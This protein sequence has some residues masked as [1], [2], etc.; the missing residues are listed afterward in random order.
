M[1]AAYLFSAIP[2]PAAEKSARA[3][4][5]VA[6]DEPAPKQEVDVSDTAS[7]REALERS[8]TE[9]A[10]PESVPMSTQSLVNGQDKT[11]VTSQAISVP[12]GAGKIEGMGESFSAQLSTGGGTFRVPFTIPAARGGV[13]PSLSLS[14]SSSG[15]QS[16]AGMG[17]NVGVP[18]IARQT[19]RG[20]PRYRDPALGG[21]WHPNQDRFVFNGGQE[22]VPICLVSGGTCPGKLD[23]ERMPA[24]AHEW[25]YFRPRVEGGFLRFFW[26]PDHKTW[27]VQSKSG[28]SMELGVPLDGSR[29]RDALE[30]SPTDESKIFRWNLVRQYDALGGAN[31]ATGQPTP[32]NITAYRYANVDGNAY[33]TDIY[34]TPPAG[35]PASAAI[36]TYA[37]HTRLRYEPRPD[38]TFSYRRGWRV[39][40]SLRLVG[41]DVATKPFGGDTSSARKLVRR[42]HLGYDPRYHPSLLASVQVEGR[43]GA[44]DESTEPM[45]EN[46]DES[47]PVSS[48][49]PRLPATTFEYQHVEPRAADGSAGIAD[50]TGFEGFDERLTT[51]AS[52]PPHSLDE[53]MTDLLDVNAD[54][55]P[56]VLV[57]E[58]GRY[59]GKH[60]VFW[61]GAGG[62]AGSFGAGTIGVQGV[63]GDNANT[64]TLRNAN[65]SPGDLDGDAVIDLVHMP[66][67]RTYSVYAPQHVGTDW[68]WVGRPITA[69]A[70]SPKVDLG[71]DATNLRRMDVN[72]DGLVDV[73]VTTGLETETFFSLGRYPG[74]DGQFGH[75]TWTSATTAEISNEPVA[76]CVP[77]RGTPVG[78]ADGDV[79]VS[80]MNGDGF[81]D[82]VRI[83][84]GEVRYWPGRGNGM[85][86]TGTPESCPAGQFG[87][88]QDIAMALAPHYADPNGSAV[89]FD[90]VNGD[91]L[92]DLVQ[93]R[94]QN[95][96]VWLN[97]DGVRW[98]DRHVIAGA[99]AAEPFASRVRLVD[100]NG[101]GTRDILWGDGNRYRFMD[102]SGGARPW[103]LTRV[104]NG[105]GKTTQIEYST[106]TAMML[107]AQ[108][109]GSPWQS[110][111]PLPLHVVTRLTTSNNLSVAGAPASNEVLEYTYR[112]PVYDGRQRE[113]RGFRVARARS[114]GDA[115]GPTA[116]TESRFLLGE[117][118]PDI[119][120]SATTCS[121]G[122]RWRDNPV[123]ALKGLPATNDTSD[124]SGVHVSTE[125]FTYRLR[126]LYAGLDGREVRHAFEA[127]HDT[128]LYDT[129]TFDASPSR[130]D[131]TDVEL[132]SSGSVSVHTSS[133]LALHSQRHRAHIRRGTE[134]DSFGNQV[135]STE[136]GCVE[137]CA[138][139]DEVTTSVGIPRLHDADASGWTWRTWETHVAGG[140][141]PA[142]RHQFFT[143]DAAGLLVSSHEEL[144]G[145]IPLLRFH[146][147][148]RSVAPA[149]P[150]ASN[151]G[152]LLLSSFERDDFGNV[153]FDNG[154]NHRCRRRSH[155][156][157]YSQLMISETLMAGAVDAAGRCGATPLE[158]TAHYDRGLA[159][160]VSARGFRGDVV[161]VAYDGFGR[162]TRLWKP[163]PARSG[164][165]SPL[166]SIEVEYF[167]PVDARVT[168]FTRVH[169][170]VQ[171]GADP[172]IAEYRESWT[173]SDG[174][175]RT[176]LILDEAD[177]EAS[178]RGQ[179][180]ATGVETY[181]TKGE[182]E[183]SYS[184]WFTDERAD[185]F[186]LAAVPPAAY[187]RQRYDAFGRAIETFAI[188]GTITLRSVY[189]ALSTDEWDAADLAAGP[190][191]GTFATT[192]RDGHGRLV[193]STVRVRAGSEIEQHE[194]RMTYLATGE[195][196][197]IARRRVGRDEA[198]FVRWMLYDSAGRLVLN[199]EPNTSADFSAAPPADPSRIK[200]WHYA[201]NDSGDL[202]GTSDA[203]GCGTNYHYD[204]GGRVVA[205]DYSP[206]ETGHAPYTPANP[207][208]GV[209]AEVYNRYDAPDAD[210][211]SIPEFTGARAWWL[212]RLASVSDRAS[213]TLMRYDGRGRLV[214]MA[215]QIARPTTGSI[216]PGNLYAPRWYVQSVQFDAAERATS[217][218]TAALDTPD[219]PLDVRSVVSTKYTKRGAVGSVG[220]SHGPL[221]ARVEHDAD[222]LI[223]EI[224]YADAA[225]TTTTFS[226]DL[227]RRLGSVQTYRGPPNQ[228]WRASP[229]AYS[230]APH[231]DERAST[232]QLVLDDLEF[233]YDSV[234]NPIE[235]RDWRDPSDWPS[236]AK[237]V[238]RKIQYDDLY[239]VS[240]IEY[241]HAG[242][243]DGWV[244]PFDAEN[245]GINRDPRRATPAPHVGF[246][247]RTRSQ[248][249][250]Y[251]WLGN[252]VSTVDDARGF[253]DRSLGAITNGSATSGP[254]QLRTASNASSS[255]AA[256]SREGRLTG[257]YDAAG[258]LV[259][260]S[261]RRDGPCLPSSA[262]C[263][264]RYAYEWDEVG[265]LSRA[266]RWDAADPWALAEPLPRPQA[267]LRY[268]YDA[269]DGRAIKASLRDEAEPSYAIYPFDALELRGAK[270]DD[271]IGDYT[272]NA[273][274]E[275]SYLFAHGVRLARVVTGGEDLP[276]AT[277]GKTHVFLELMDHI[278]STTIV[279]DRETSELVERVTYLG[280]GTDDSDYRPERW[281][282]FREDYR[283]TGKEEDAEVGIT[284][285]KKRFYAPRLNRWM[286]ADPL[287]I[288]A[289]AADLNVYAYVS[290]RALRTN[291]PLGLNPPV[292]PLPASAPGISGG[293]MSAPG[294][295][296]LPVN[297]PGISP[298]SRWLYMPPNVAPAPVSAPGAATGAAEGSTALRYIAGVS[299]VGGPLA[300]VTLVVLICATGAPLPNA[301]APSAQSSQMPQATNS[302]VVGQASWLQVTRPYGENKQRYP[303][304]QAHHLNQDAA[305]RPGSDPNDPNKGIPRN[306]GL[307]IPLPGN[308]FTEPGTPHYEF[309][310]AMEAF[311]DKFREGGSREFQRP[312]NEEYTEALQEALIAAG[313]SPQEAAA[314]AAA[315][316]Q[317]R[318]QKGMNEKDFVPRVPGKIW[319]RPDPNASMPPENS[320]GGDETL[321]PPKEADED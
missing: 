213:R 127:Q 108:A 141:T 48:A 211:Q 56:D 183:R 72:G 139:A 77:W 27:R 178:D 289:A 131:V 214:G 99:P 42:Y 223:R 262:V 244:S 268:V 236:G 97:V 88:D 197:R 296:T 78:F 300:I 149:P 302:C 100:I 90:D 11:G 168:P 146:E 66:K 4:E 61:N 205:E 286:S 138:D 10:A 81:A 177:P 120:G 220:S 117:C 102:L 167:L 184:P 278:A 103:V 25:Q 186:P 288:H 84:Q 297:A 216:E 195:T 6:R 35:N 124:E 113:F 282:S 280:Y 255:P 233:A 312:R 64:I 207:A 151:D 67:V 137:G 222:G 274:T 46:G 251:D 189:H 76:T 201:Y 293:P 152:M 314:V 218:S 301:P 57:T 147:D 200:A 229:P 30:S 23:A 193:S 21:A 156:P 82:I 132:E 101:S 194:T 259:G 185:A 92:D 116:T 104:A 40:Q 134:I 199:V 105:L 144:S 18:F 17:W 143:Y 164:E 208:T 250:R 93:I 142:R 190:H 169:T 304:W 311:W 7:E 135:R 198:P 260:L 247:D 309:H 161:A 34:S 55:L 308:A 68:W 60:G 231:A 182:V 52:S 157:A 227:R 299:R 85:W 303:G 14:Y 32:V 275:V 287:A 235:I 53:E 171:R 271:G 133:T 154:P 321:K 98:T 246:S 125:H 62:S 266:Q 148:G 320:S 166:P 172:T 175:G 106:S 221:V 196:S 291:D 316:R 187:E 270:W 292:A 206:C 242:G 73:V 249:F 96:D 122:E 226:Y 163:D 276:S 269:T 12:Q 212:G 140:A 254:N 241:Q 39:V 298:N 130:Q 9:L 112:D 136:Y 234:D 15:G 47:L 285:F 162:V 5:R 237:P 2:A 295:S 217:E 43:C 219:G 279:V 50:L 179:W 1:H 245:R 16:I 74:G 31:A 59:G 107:A 306:E 252:T 150:E 188:D 114:L 70:Q 3:P 38:P 87:A 54:G 215:R 86:G 126:H 230:P 225:S 261:I 118:K 272:R 22:L 58:P 243:R 160:V 80:D 202:V 69:Q 180:I 19:D 294:P 238:S 8:A 37:H 110:T 71:K 89:R 307:T 28:E 79:H 33:L 153:V 128:Y 284:Y 248:S 317:Q 75:A 145:T 44:G 310:H 51:I 121:A 224:V 263:S 192:Q 313:L 13:S 165:H 305:F 319:Q 155:D 267:D 119:A 94:F 173:Y 65:V 158:A 29:Y 174:A 181:D 115:N 20:V 49:C 36:A 256:T 264:Q 283:F 129:A 265:H 240:R 170:R 253:Y 277:S 109:A 258:N 24:W 91:G 203:R 26:S 290:G 95:V 41:V 209:G 228:L 318:E 83:R 45:Q 281:K 111:A 204:A 239:R 123:E 159:A 315:A 273:D 210:A 232:F 63:L 176:R 191:H 257:E